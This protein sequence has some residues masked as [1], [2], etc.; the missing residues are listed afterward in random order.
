[1]KG[2]MR[3]SNE[4]GLAIPNP[5]EVRWSVTESYGTHIVGEGTATLS[6][7]GGWEGEW[8]I[9]EKIKTGRYDVRCKLDKQ[10]YDGV[11]AISIEEYRVPA[12]SVVVEA[13]PEVG[14][15]AHAHVSSAYFHGAPN[16]GARVHW[17]AT[18]IATAEFD[19]RNE[20]NKRRYNSFAEVGPRQDPENEQIKTA[21][22]D[23]KLDAH[24]FADFASESPFKDDRAIGKVSV[25]WRAEV[26]SL[27]GQTIVGGDLASL[28]PAP[29]LLGISA[30]GKFGRTPRRRS[31]RRRD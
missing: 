14:D 28:F 12:F 21:E 19:S 31:E 9:P 18:W 4:S 15:T 23:T 26:T 1:M 30:H 16:A 10:D 7:D 27:D 24:G 6:T 17:K 29:A 13:K 8:N 3:E 2:L 11:T 25:S 5:A 20:V 22:G